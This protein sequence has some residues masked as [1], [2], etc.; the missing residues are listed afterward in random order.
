MCVIVYDYIQLSTRHRKCGSNARYKGTRLALVQV[1][2][3]QQ[4][5]S[6]ARAARMSSIRESATNVASAKRNC[7]HSPPKMSI[8]V[9]Y[10]RNATPKNQRT[11]FMARTVFQKY[12]RMSK[13]IPHLLRGR[14][15]TDI[16]RVLP[17]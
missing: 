17:A 13:I 12:P 15:E 9:A 5:Q 6:W 8:P 3:P 1:G 11:E 10:V 14:S 7:R 16:V 4:V 2:Y